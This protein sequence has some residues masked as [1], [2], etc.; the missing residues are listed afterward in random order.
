MLNTHGPKAAICTV[1]Q[2]LCS[3]FQVSIC[4]SDSIFALK[5]TAVWLTACRE[6]ATEFGFAEGAGCITITERVDWRTLRRCKG[7]RRKG[8]CRK[9]E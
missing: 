1:F 2:V 4:G 5:G 9:R 8:L 7:C 6:S 3:E